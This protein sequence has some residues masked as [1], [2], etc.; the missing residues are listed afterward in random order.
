MLTIEK[1]VHKIVMIG[2]RF[3]RGSAENVKTFLGEKF[4]VC[5]V[6]RPDSDLSTLMQ[7]MK[8]DINTL[9]NN[10]ILLRGGGSNDLEKKEF[11]TALKLTTEFIK[12]NNFTNL[13]V[14]L[15]DMTCIA[16]HVSNT[17]RKYK[18]N[19]SKITQVHDHRKFLEQEIDWIF[20][21]RHRL[22]FNKLGKFQLAKQVVSLYI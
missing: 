8:K 6:V 13:L 5:S 16:T 19:Q 11:K 21:A 18:R 1:K 4:D 20:Y 9:T 12:Q 15:I 22:H 17:I 10:D 7:S 3:F 14:F 2:D